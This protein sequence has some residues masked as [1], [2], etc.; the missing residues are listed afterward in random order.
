VRKRSAF[1]VENRSFTVAARLEATLF[2]D[3]LRDENVKR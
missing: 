2:G 1:A 3:A